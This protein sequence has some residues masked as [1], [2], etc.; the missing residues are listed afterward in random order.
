MW[1]RLVTFE[2][3][4][5]VESNSAVATLPGEGFVEEGA[6]IHR[7]KCSVPAVSSIAVA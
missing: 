5:F 6:Q 4:P 3:R 1:Y 2:N 7:F